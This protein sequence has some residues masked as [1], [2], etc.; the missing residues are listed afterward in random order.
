MK[1][2]N[3]ETGVF[4]QMMDRFEAFVKKMDELCRRRGNKNLQKWLENQDVC[5]ILN[6]SKRTLQTYR[7]N[8]TLPFSQISRKIYYRPEDVERLIRKLKTK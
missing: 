7:G 4:E 1:I 3:I 5:E 2:I 8:G 6:I